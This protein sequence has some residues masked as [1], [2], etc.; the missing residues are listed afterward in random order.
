MDQIYFFTYSPVGCFTFTLSKESF[1]HNKYHSL[2]DNKLSVSNLKKPKLCMN[3]RLT[4]DS[5]KIPLEI[6]TED[7]IT[8]WCCNVSCGM[9]LVIIHGK[10]KKLSP[11]IFHINLFCVDEQHI[12][13]LSIPDHSV[14]D[15]VSA[16]IHIIWK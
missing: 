15:H 1:V 12:F 11:N 8:L 13:S 5:C 9:F 2:L 7:R 4:I 16:N 6:Y 3:P 14:I 10:K